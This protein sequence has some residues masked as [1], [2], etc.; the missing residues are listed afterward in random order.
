VTHVASDTVVLVERHEKRPAAVDDI[1]RYSFVD[2]LE[3]DDPPFE[4]G[5]YLVEAAVGVKVVGR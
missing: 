1:C 2:V 3:A 5:T 4:A